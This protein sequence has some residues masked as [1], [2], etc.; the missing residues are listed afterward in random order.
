MR[1]GSLQASIA[2]IAA[3]LV[4]REPNRELD[5][6]DFV[7]INLINMNNSIDEPSETNAVF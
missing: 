4:T 2:C 6:R 3:G 5:I 7:N 1:A